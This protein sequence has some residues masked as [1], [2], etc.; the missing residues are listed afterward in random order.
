MRGSTLAERV[1]R[2]GNAMFA[3]DAAHGALPTVAAAALPEARG[4]DYW[5]PASRTG[6]RGLPGNATPSSNATDVAAAR[7]LWTLSEQLTGV[8]YDALVAS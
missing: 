2:L 6:W 4:G 1:A 7:R 8:T 5:G 3:Q